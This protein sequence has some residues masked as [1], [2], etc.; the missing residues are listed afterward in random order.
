M[1]IIG[2]KGM[3][4]YLMKR[5]KLGRIRGILF[6]HRALAMLYARDPTSN[7]SMLT[8]KSVLVGR[9][10]R[11]CRFSVTCVHKNASSMIPQYISAYAAGVTFLLRPA[12]ELTSFVSDASFEARHNS[13]YLRDQRARKSHQRRKETE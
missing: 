7:F 6:C 8:P 11:F 9:R 5:S 2:R 1:K 4:A 10:G 12:D 13:V 3:K